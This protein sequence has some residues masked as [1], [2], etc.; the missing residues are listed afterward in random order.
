MSPEMNEKPG[1]TI[2]PLQNWARKATWK[3]ISILAGIKKFKSL[4]TSYKSGGGRGCN[5]MNHSNAGNTQC[6]K[7]RL[8][9]F[10]WLRLSN[11]ESDLAGKKVVKQSLRISPALR[12]MGAARAPSSVSEGLVTNHDCA[13]PLVTLSLARK[14]ILKLNIIQ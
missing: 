13:S 8:S 5:L 3:G 6:L 12:E 2:I 4:P 11:Q 7:V 14:Y 10:K 9:L 1:R